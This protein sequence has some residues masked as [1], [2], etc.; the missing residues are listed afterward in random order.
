[1]TRPS[2]DSASRREFESR[3]ASAIA[4]LPEPERDAVVYHL[5]G[6]LTFKEMARLQDAPDSTVATW[7]YRALEKLR[8]ELK[9]QP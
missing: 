9:E 3:L 8:A 6:E 5:Y 4:S 7:Y 1:M 2:V